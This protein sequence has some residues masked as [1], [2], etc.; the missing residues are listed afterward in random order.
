M[1]YLSF[2]YTTVSDKIKQQFQAEAL[3]LD[4]GKLL[5]TRS[6]DFRIVF[7]KAVD[8]PNAYLVM[9]IGV[10]DQILIELANKCEFPRGFPVLWIPGIK[11][12]Y[13]G[14]YPKFENDD[15]QTPDEQSDF[16]NIKSIHFF[17]KW[18]GFLGQL[19]FFTINDQKYWTVTSKNSAGKDSPYIEDGKRL[20]EPFINQEFVDYMI[21]NNLHICA[22]VMSQ[23][24]QVHGSIVLKEFPIITSIGKGCLYNLDGLLPNI[25]GL[26]FVEFFSHIELVDLCVKFG[27]PC[28]SAVIIDDPST[29]SQFVKRLSSRRDFMT[30]SELHKFLSEYSSGIIF[31]KGTVNHCDILG[32]CLEGLVLKFVHTNGSTSVKKYKFPGYTIRT[33]LFRET[34]EKFAFSQS[35]KYATKRFCDHWCVTTEG[36]EYWYN[37]GLQG[38][39]N[40][41]TFKS[42]DKNIGEH[43]HI[44]ESTIPTPETEKVFNELA[45]KLSSGTIIMCIGPIGSGKTSTAEVIASQDPS[46]YVYIDGDVLGFSMDLVLK[47]GKE[48]NDYTKWLVIKALMDGKI[49][50]ISTGGGTLFSTGKN[51][52]FVLRDQI[53]SILGIIP[54]IILM[55]PDQVTQITQLDSKYD[56]SKLYDDVGAVRKVVNRRINTKEWTIDSKFKN[57]DQFAT[58]IAK[59][60]KENYRFAM[61][62]I[63]ASDYIFGFPVISDKNFGIQKKLDYSNVF[64]SINPIKSNFNGKFGQIRILTKIGT[65]IGHITYEF[66]PNCDLEYSLEKFSKLLVLCDSLK[67]NKSNKIHGQMITLTS[68]DKKNSLSVAYPLRCIHEDGSTHITVNPGTHAP[69]EMKSVVKA[70]KSGDKTIALSI[71]NSKNTIE[72]NFTNMTLSPCVIEVLGVFGI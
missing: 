10:H 47:F 42:P 60:S 21:K 3:G 34:F 51:Q 17:K 23:R 36:R 59:K 69:K 24:D 2:E 35:L 45:I 15:R 5:T 52:K 63:Q 27:L 7:H 32:D 46:L 53:Y 14:F 31:H 71:N 56:P 67:D 26:K 72:Y 55:I 54:K 12:Q 43:I 49:P 16:N 19:M 44:A 6:K 41:L 58:F 66:S 25:G 20:F 57:I 37:F 40:K 68:A 30:D 1:S 38:F 33:M 13:F 11:M 8:V 61:Q 62:L 70:Y 50:V 22:E 28:D 48:R 39:I 4:L 64:S 18:S 65:E 9:I 29:A